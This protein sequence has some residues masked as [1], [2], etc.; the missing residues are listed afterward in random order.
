MGKEMDK[1][2][3]KN[4]I[5]RAENFLLFCIRDGLA[6]S[7]DTEKNMWVKSYPEV[8]GYLL[9]YFSEVY[10]SIPSKIIEAA[11]R[12]ICIQNKIGGFNSFFGENPLFSFDTAQIVHGLLSIYKKTNVD[13]YLESAKR[14][15]SFLEKAQ[16]EDGSIL[17]IYDI[18]KQSFVK[19]GLGFHSG[20]ER[21][22]I[23]CK[24]IECFLLAYKIIGDKKYEDIAKRLYNFSLVSPYN[25]QTHPLG[26]YLEGITSYGNNDFVKNILENKVISRIKNNGFLSYDKNLPYSYVSGSIQIGIL[27]YKNNF[28]R[29]S[30][31]ILEWASGVQSNS[32]SG[33][34]FQYANEDCSINRDVHSE[35]N[36]WGT[37]YY[38]QLNRLFLEN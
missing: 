8:T 12:L 9:S 36:S 7:F 29:E 3:I 33:G 30:K 18:Y 10:N 13:I 38:C 5:E 37:K 11:N 25:E 21:H 20:K 15:L 26:Y 4:N 27:L 1:N 23:Q 6:H 19:E 17:G 14:G 16:Q 31:K 32:K 24:N 28:I 35:I 22:A 2:S 34:L